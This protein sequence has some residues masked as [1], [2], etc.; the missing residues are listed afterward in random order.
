M[1][2]LVMGMAVLSSSNDRPSSNWVT[3]TACLPPDLVL[4]IPVVPSASGP[5]SRDS[6]MSGFHS[7][8]VLTSDQIRQTRAGAALVSMDA[9]RNAMSPLLS[10]SSAEGL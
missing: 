5:L 4:I 2:I 3:T 6:F 8:Q 1:A 10:V 9:S 7:G